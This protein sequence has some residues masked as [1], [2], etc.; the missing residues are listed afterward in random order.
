MSKEFNY[1]REW[2]ERK[3]SERKLS[4]SNLTVETGHRITNATIFRWY[5]GTFR[6]TTD[7]LD[8]VCK[9]LSKIPILEE[10][11][12]PRFEEVSPWEALS[13]FTPK[14]E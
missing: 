10:G 1:I 12:Q 8:I 14:G 11:R 9:A 6:P 7:K 5:N 2:L 3:L 13:Q 4:V